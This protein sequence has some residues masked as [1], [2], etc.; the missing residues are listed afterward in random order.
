MTGWTELFGSTSDDMA[1]TSAKSVPKI[2]EARIDHYEGRLSEAKTEREAFEAV[3]NELVVDR[4]MS[5]ADTIELAQ[6]YRG[7]GSKPG[8]KK[9]ALEVISKRFLELIRSRNQIK[10]ASKAR[11][12]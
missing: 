10:Q 7:G 2:N 4:N 12:W 5:V 1:R 3:F 11:P 6:R 9:A 8:S